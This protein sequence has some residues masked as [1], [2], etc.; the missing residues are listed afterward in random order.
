MCLSVRLFCNHRPQNRISDA[1][2]PES[3][4]PSALSERS[5]VTDAAHAQ[6]LATEHWSLLATRSMTW[7]E[8]FSRSSLYITV[9]PVALLVGLATRLRLGAANGEE[10]WLLLGMSRLRHGSLELAPELEPCCV[11]ASHDDARSVLASYGMGTRLSLGRLLAGTPNLVAAITIVAL[12]AADHVALVGGLVAVFLATLGLAAFALQSITRDLRL[13]HP[14]FPAS[15]AAVL[16]SASRRTTCDRATDMV[17]CPLLWRGTLA[18]ARIAREAPPP[19][20]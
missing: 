15:G 12:G 17:H 6:L 10:F 3:S 16:W 1:L 5:G 20:S 11:T 14:R 8:V 9:L 7:N 4:V 19:P 2:P 13:R 18:D